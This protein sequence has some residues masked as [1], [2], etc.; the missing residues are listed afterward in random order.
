M[1]V[2]S[3]KPGEKITLIRRST[4]E[5]IV[6]TQ[7]RIGPNTSRLG[8]EAADHWDIY[9][10]EL[11]DDGTDTNDNPNDTPKDDPHADS[12]RPGPTA[13]EVVPH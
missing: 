6:L 9:R 11:E 2:L 10:N 4:G 5:K 1:L 3:R 12:N 7:V 8:I 13:E